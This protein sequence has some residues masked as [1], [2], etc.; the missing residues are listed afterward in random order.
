[1]TDKKT[2]KIVSFVNTIY[3]L[4]SFLSYNACIG[5]AGNNMSLINNTSWFFI[6]IFKYGK[7]Q[8]SIDSAL[9]V[10]RIERVRFRGNVRSLPRDK[11]N[12][13]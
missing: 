11:G 13:Q 7:K 9:T 8:V 5:Y 12:C 4:W 3:L 1:M 2:T 10:V 6:T